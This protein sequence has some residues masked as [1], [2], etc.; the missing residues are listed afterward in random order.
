[1]SNLPLVSIIIPCRNEKKFIARCLESVL[2]N[3]YSKDKIE[4]FI[5]DG[6]S[7]DGTREIIKD[8]IQKYH[9]IKLI[10]NHKY[11]ASSALNIGVRESKGIIIVRMDAHATYDKSYISKCVSYLEKYSADNVG[12]VISIIPRKNTFIGRGIAKAMS[13]ILGTGGAKYK[14]GSKKF[15]EVDTVP[16]GC[17]RRNVFNRIG[18][19]NENLK[20]SQDM[21][22]NLRLRKVGGKIYLFSDVV[23]Y[24]YVR[25]SLK[26]F[27][28]HNFEDGIWAIYPL[29]FT[30]TFFKLRH[31]APLVF[32]FGLIITF[33][34]GIFSK[35]F[36]YFF[37]FEIF[38]Y[39][40]II[41][42]AAIKVSVDE[43][44]GTYLFSLP[45]ALATRHFAYGLGSIFGI[46]K[47][48]K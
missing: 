37:L 9:F 43:K 15:E 45:V 46:I 23:S 34:M 19:F 38:A 33:F 21:D 11:I 28:V 24:Y 7:I 27:F 25:S 10:D 1:M 2:E 26:D 31:Y 30:K 6:M 18:F 4:I 41:L 17:F 40:L 44:D 32:V 48:L 3:D 12:G 42:C 35:L 5:V 22:F 39:A 8:Y 13:S 47:L 29:K 14:T 20:R 16:F 36:Y